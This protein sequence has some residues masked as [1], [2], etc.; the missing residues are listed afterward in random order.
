M[1]G[2]D[3]PLPTLSAG[4]LTLRPS[5]PTD[6]EPLLVM[7]AH[8]EV[9]EWWGDNTASSLAEEIAG[10]FTIT[11]DGETAG[12]LLAHKETDPTYPS[13][14]FDIM[15]GVRFHGH[16]HGRRALRLA[17]DHYVA[18]GHHRFTIDP[19]VGN[20]AALQCYSAVGFQPVGILR[21]SERAPSGGWRDAILM[22]LLAREL[23]E[24]GA[25]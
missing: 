12:I 21:E 11:V 19:S 22:D 9:A 13:V 3:E 5:D 25:S 18:R 7:L 16:G 23:P 6:I 10:Q 2:S 4:A 14:A 1:A 15:L 17:I 20:T 8:P 24:S